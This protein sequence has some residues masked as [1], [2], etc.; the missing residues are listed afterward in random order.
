MVQATEGSVDRMSCAPIDGVGP[1]RKE[2]REA[3][4]P[5]TVEIQTLSACEPARLGRP[6]LLGLFVRQTARSRHEEKPD[7]GA[8]KYPTALR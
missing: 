6:G 8:R 1:K 3:R 7:L 2:E 5:G 4:T